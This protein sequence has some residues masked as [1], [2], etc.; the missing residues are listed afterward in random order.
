M[1]RNCNTFAPEFIPAGIYTHLNFAFAT[2][3][4]KTFEVRP[5]ALADKALYSRLTGLK[6]RDPSLKVFIAI[7]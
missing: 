1:E 3:D 7:G 2:I 6:K 4:P 5:A